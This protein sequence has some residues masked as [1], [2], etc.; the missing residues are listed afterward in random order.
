MYALQYHHNM[1]WA[2]PLVHTPPP[3]TMPMPA[4]HVRVHM[5]PPAVARHRAGMLKLPMLQAPMPEVLQR[6]ASRVEMQKP[7]LWVLWML[8]MVQWIAFAAGSA[9][10]NDEQ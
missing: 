7:E 4:Q 2:Q 5:A 3:V 1:A 6:D 8:F 10:C 9:S